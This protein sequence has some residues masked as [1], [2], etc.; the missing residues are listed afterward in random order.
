MAGNAGKKVYMPNRGHYQ[1]RNYSQGRPRPNNDPV[2]FVLVF[3]IVFV[4]VVASFYILLGALEP[5]KPKKHFVEVYVHYDDDWSGVLG[6]GDSTSSKSAHGEGKFWGNLSDGSFVYISAQKYDDT[7][8][9]I[10]VEIY[11]D[12]IL[13]RTASSTTPYGI[14]STSLVL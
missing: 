5:P 10:S 8:K 9:K 13:V 12:G 1:T 7:N 2:K 6:W 3:V 4:L 11:V 14:A